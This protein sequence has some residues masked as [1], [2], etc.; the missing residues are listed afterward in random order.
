LNEDCGIFDAGAIE[1][2]VVREGQCITINCYTPGYN[3]NFVSGIA[4]A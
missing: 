3:N 2:S 1:G 4:H